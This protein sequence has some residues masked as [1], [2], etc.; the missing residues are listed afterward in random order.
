M[1]PDDVQT[2][3]RLSSELK[4]SLIKAAAE[5]GRSL[6][7][8]VSFRLRKT[9]DPVAVLDQTEGARLRFQI[10]ELEACDAVVRS[11]LLSLAY[12]A[13]STLDLLRSDLTPK[14]IQFVEMLEAKTTVLI[15][16][17]AETSSD[18]DAIRARLDAAG[19]AL[20]QCI[21]DENRRFHQAEDM[22]LSVMVDSAATAVEMLTKN[23]RFFRRLQASGDV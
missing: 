9:F 8:E 19:K 12:T 13:R 21:E 22:D 23:G 10:R 14:E 17:L 5:N 16:G 4:D 6:S 20:I 7:A 11:E 18:L 3:I 15:D 1:V 2:N